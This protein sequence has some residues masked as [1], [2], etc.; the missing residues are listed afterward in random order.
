MIRREEDGISPRNR[1]LVILVGAAALV[2]V[3][4]AMARYMRQYF[5]LLFPFAFGVAPV[6][7]ALLA[8]GASPEDIRARKVARP[9]LLLVAFLMA[10]GVVVGIFANHALTGR[11]P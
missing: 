7:G 8:S 4:L 2:L 5:A 1:G 10:A 11:M 6:G 9:W 3:N